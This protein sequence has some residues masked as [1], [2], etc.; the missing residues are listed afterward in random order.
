MK[1]VM[2]GDYLIPTDLMLSACEPLREAGF[3]IET[4]E[5]E[6]ESKEKV[7]QRR[8]NVELHGPEAEAY[9][10]GADEAV[11]DAQIL[12]VH[13]CPVPRSLI[14]AGSQLKVIGVARAGWEN[15]D[16]EAATERNIPVIHIVGRNDI[17]VAEFT[18]GLM[19]A[20]MRHIARAHCAISQGE[21]FEIIDPL[22]CFELGGKTIGLIGFGAVGRILARRLAGFEARLLV[23][24]PYVPEEVVREA[25]CEPSS[26]EAILEQSDVVSLHARLTSETL[27]LIGKRELA[28]MKPTAYL[29]NTARAGLIDEDALLEA[30]KERRIAGAA[31]DVLWQEPVPAD[32]PFLEL[33]N[34]TLVSHLAGTT[35][36]AFIKSVRLVTQAALDCIKAVNHDWVVNP[37]AIRKGGKC[38]VIFKRAHS[39]S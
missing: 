17:T 34:V 13:F 8:L 36:D 7:D 16:I 19:L 14:E 1:A 2:I 15:I 39:P 18:I 35:G 10:D 31:L 5:W 26:L 6:T 23:Y 3:E 4:L 21:W 29:I 38:Q 12:I 32:S 9:A 11:K 30:L 20:E 27:G 28:L 22:S 25:G 33:D 37:E 24:D